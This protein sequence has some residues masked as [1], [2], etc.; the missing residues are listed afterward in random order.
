MGQVKKSRKH[1]RY[2]A[3]RTLRQVTHAT[4]KGTAVIFMAN[5]DRKSRLVSLK[6]KAMYPPHV[7]QAELLLSG[8]FKWTVYCAVFCRSVT[9]SYMKSLEVSVSEPCTHDTLFDSMPDQHLELLKGCNDSQV[10]NVGWLASP[11]GLSISESLAG[12]L[13]DKHGAWD[14]LTPWELAAKEAS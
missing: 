12:E 13:F 2:D 9:Q 11:E 8:Q 3:Q 5:N 10:V 4:L 1:K 7:Q 6:T 14:G